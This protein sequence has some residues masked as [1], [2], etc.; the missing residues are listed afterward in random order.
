[1][2]HK[3]A[4]R[5]GSRCMLR[6]VATLPHR[7]SR[8]LLCKRIVAYFRRDGAALPLMTIS[9]LEKGDS[10]VRHTSH[11][12]C[13]TN[14]SFGYALVTGG[15]SL[16]AF[17]VNCSLTRTHARTHARTPAHARARTCTLH[18]NHC[19]SICTPCPS[20]VCGLCGKLRARSAKKHS[21]TANTGNK[22]LFLILGRCL[23]MCEA[24]SFSVRICCNWHL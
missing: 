19:I 4:S 16:F 21:L 10:R 17:G 14:R 5:L 11:S 9:G 6:Q 2:E 20:A 1:M 13:R 12:A 22:G 24:L 7:P 15:K 23:H 3:W 18:Y 8:F